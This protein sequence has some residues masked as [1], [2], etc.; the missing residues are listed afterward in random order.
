[1][2]QNKIVLFGDSLSQI[3][4]KWKPWLTWGAKREE[5]EK[6]IL[7]TLTY[8]RGGE[9]VLRIYGPF[10]FSRG[11]FKERS[12]SSLA[13]RRPHFGQRGR[14]W[15]R[16]LT[17]TRSR[18]SCPRPRRSSPTPSRTG[19][20]SARSSILKSCS[21]SGSTPRSHLRRY[22]VASLVSIRSFGH[23]MAEPTSL[24]HFNIHVTLAEI[25]N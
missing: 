19:Q 14:P 6:K 2:C 20:L 16:G 13:S 15:I 3:L 11:R 18:S 7:E 10:E 1:M 24:C 4:A 9:G 12:L 8:V 23:L 5:R 21:E 17:S 25:W 22:E